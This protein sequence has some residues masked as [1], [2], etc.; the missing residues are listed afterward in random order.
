LVG[1]L[2]T[3][4]LHAVE[5]DEILKDQKLEERARALSSELRCLVCQNQSIDDSHA[6]LA[7][8]LRVLVR[9]KLVGG[10][11]DDAIRAFLVDRYGE[12]ILL[13]PRFSADTLILWITPFCLLALG[14]LVLIRKS[15][16]AAE[17][18]VAVLD[19]DEQ[20]RLAELLNAENSTG[21]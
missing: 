17:T 10:D 16:K 7:K 9:Q 12:F 20:A 1:F 14:G 6:P 15:R 11:S 3:T 8:D 18:Q 4:P 2:V 13:K 19:G 21:S 5:P